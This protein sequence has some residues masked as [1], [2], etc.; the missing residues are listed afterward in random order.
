MAFFSWQAPHTQ[1]EIH[2]SCPP[3]LRQVHAKCAA[4]TPF[5]PLARL[6]IREPPRDRIIGVLCY[7]CWTPAGHRDG[8]SLLIGLGLVIV[9]VHLRPSQVL[10][11]GDPRSRVPG[12]SYMQLRM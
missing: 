1:S 12:L 5:A 2:R 9:D 3:A 7:L 6:M 11:K 8:P 10:G 4:G